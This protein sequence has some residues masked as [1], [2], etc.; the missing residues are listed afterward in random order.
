MARGNRIPMSEVLAAAEMLSE[1][2]P[3]PED[4]TE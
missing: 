1:S 4:K 2:T 3:P